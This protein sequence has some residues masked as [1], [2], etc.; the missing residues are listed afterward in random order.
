VASAAVVGRG[1]KQL[2]AR[3]RYRPAQMRFA[4]A[5]QALAGPAIAE[6]EVA[7]AAAAGRHQHAVGTAAQR[8]F[9]EGR[10]QHAGADQADHRG[11]DGGQWSGV[12]TARAGKDD[13]RWRPSSRASAAS[14]CSRS[15]L[16][17]C[18]GMSMPVTRV[19]RRRK[20][21][22]EGQEPAQMPQAG[23]EVG[24]DD[25]KLETRPAA[26]AGASRSRRRGSRPGSGRS[27][28]S[29]PGRRPLP[30]VVWREAAAAARRA[31]REAEQQRPDDR[32]RVRS[33]SGWMNR[34]NQSKS[35]APGTVARLAGG[36]LS[37]GLISSERT[38][39][40]ASVRQHH[41]P[42][43]QVIDMADAMHM[44]PEAEDQQ[45]RHADMDED[46]HA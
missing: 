30:A 25:G 5:E 36:L 26:G 18:C 10:W 24:I 22:D 7:A 28:C 14:S 27:R 42:R 19:S 38:I 23:A 13:Y 34:M 16:T 8:V 43:R 3:G 9:D 20:G 33:V 39:S 11:V 32:R 37:A 15:A 46:Q 40:A 17:G 12:G 45:Q 21:V 35:S 4:L 6:A 44:R 2:Q 1:G 31:A 29:W 41:A